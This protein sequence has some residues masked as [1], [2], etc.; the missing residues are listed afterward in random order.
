MGSNAA[1]KGADDPPLDAIAALEGADYSASAAEVGNLPGFQGGGGESITGRRTG[2][3]GPWG[4][5]RTR[6]GCEQ[7]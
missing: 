1:R 5:G 6:E 7:G 2:L 3:R 4:F